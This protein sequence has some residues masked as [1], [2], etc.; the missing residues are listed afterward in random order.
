MNQ[1]KAYVLQHSLR[2]AKCMRDCYL[3]RKEAASLLATVTLERCLRARTW[4]DLPGVLRQLKGLGPV[5]VRTL[6]LRGIKSFEK[7]RQTEPE[8]LEVWCKRSTPFGREI[9]KSLERVPKYQLEV[10][11]RGQV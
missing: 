11:K 1:D 10:N 7:L 2:I 5:Y 3:H 9:L 6:A 4:H 8:E